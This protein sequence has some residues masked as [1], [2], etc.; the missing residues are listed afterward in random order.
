MNEPL[1]GSLPDVIPTALNVLT[2]GGVPAQMAVRALQDTRRIVVWLVDGLGYDQLMAALEFELMP[3]LSS[4][5]RSQ[6][7]SVR[8]IQTVYPSVTPVAL[9]SL[10]TGSWPG[11]HGLIGRFLKE[12]PAIP[13]V[14]TLGRRS[15]GVSWSLLE[16]T[17]DRKAERWG[18][19]Y[20][21]LMEHRLV[22]G[23]LT[24][25]LHPMADRMVS[26][27]SPWALATRMLET[28]SHADRGL[29]YVYWPYL[30]AINHQRGP[31]SRDWGDE[32]AGLDRVLGD[33]TV[34]KSDGGSPVWLWIVADHGHQ[35]IRE[36]LPYWRLCQ[37]MPELPAVP[38]GTDRMAGLELTDEQA[39]TLSRLVPDLYGDSVMLRRTDELFEAGD[40]GP[41]ARP[42]VRDRL[43]NWILEA[44]DGCVWVWEPGTEGGRVANHGGRSPMEM[45]VPFVE[46]CLG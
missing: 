34:V 43:G 22:D 4:L 36:F 25:I 31:Y 33:L 39:E 10:L 17:L 7:G 35:T 3:N 1:A 20:E 14:D 41:V 40:F 5:I 38:L 19:H 2:R 37:K 32:M 28:A 26:Y 44:R 15:Q 21:V 42:E 8:G 29:S 13:W 45:T 23:T 30:D 18:L 46:I 9:A 6:E 27:I 12:S 11:Q 16:D 24:Q